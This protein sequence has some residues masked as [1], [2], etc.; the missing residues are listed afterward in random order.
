MTDPNA[1]ADA[2]DPRLYGTADI[3]HSSLRDYLIAAADL[4]RAQSKTLSAIETYLASWGAGNAPEAQAILD[5]IGGMLEEEDDE[6]DAVASSGGL[7]P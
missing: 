6:R 5:V 4:L 2:I 1:I 7:L 3:R